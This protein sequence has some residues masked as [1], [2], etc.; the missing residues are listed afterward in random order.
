MDIAR[1]N[2]ARQK[3]RRQIIYIAVGIVCLA[4][5]T[6]G[7]SRLKPAAPTVERSTVWIDTVK[8]GSVLRQVRGLGTLVPMEGSIQWIPA[9]TEGRV[10]K[11]LELPGTSV[12]PETVL[13]EMSNPQLQQ[14]TLDASLKLKADE[15]DYKNLQTQLAS[16]VLAQKSVAAQAQ[17]EYSQ[18]KMQADIDTQLARLGVISQ[19][20]EKVSNQKADELATRNDIEKQRLVNSTEVLQAQLQAKQAEL[21]QIRALANLKQ[22]QFAKLTVRAGISGVLQELPLKVGQWVTPGTTL[23]KVVQPQRLKAE[24]K[25]AE[26]QAKDIQLGQPASVDTHNGVISGHVTRIDPSVQNGTVSVDV[27]LDS[28]LPQGARPDLSVDGTIDL[29]KMENVLYVGR[30]AFGQEQST[31]GMFKLEPDGTTAVRAQVKL[32]R[33]SVNTVEILQGLQQGDQV[34]LSDMSRWDNFDRIRLE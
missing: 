11:I 4:L 30:P 13:L 21:E 25:I 17:S 26:T 20:S 15:A 12:K 24:L 23:A 31:V 33:S 16:Q 34:V 28:A 5:V 6:M 8:R 10:D 32:G 22:E 7:L 19:L 3:R 27:A 18:A 29:E 14:E 9:I 2:V 1:P